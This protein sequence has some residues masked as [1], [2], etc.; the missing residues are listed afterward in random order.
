MGR[1]APAAAPVAANEA[2][3]ANTAGRKVLYWYDP[4][5]P[6]QHFDKPGKSPFMDMQL[7]PKYADEGGGAGGVRIDPD[8]AQN[9]GIRLASVQRGTFDAPIDVVANV[10]FNDRDVAVVQAR[11]GGFVQRVYARAPGDVIARGAPL[12][13]LLVP[14]WGGAQGEFL[15][16]LRTGDKSLIDAARERLTLLGMPPGLIARVERTGTSH[17]TFT[18]TA[19]IGG[20]IQS[21][22]VREGMTIAAGMTLAKINGLST[23]WLE[24]AVPESQGGLVSVGHPAEAHLAAYPGE[25]FKGKVI[26]V[27]P[28]TDT[29]SRTLKVRVELPN[30]DG[31]LK[32]GM[33]AQVRL[34]TGKTQ[35]VLMIP[36]EAVIRT[37]VRNVVIVAQNGGRYAPVEVRLGQEAA[38][39]TAILAGLSEGQK[40]VA[41]GQFLIDSE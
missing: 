25:T 21:L 22:D 19:P 28:Q 17:D 2:P 36:T 18:I 33:F 24:A 31:R 1:S 5:M 16:V 3:A 9:L 23:V 40:V 20:V 12:A 8:M 27:L 6:N 13:D 35:P 4:M 14:E 7:V 37:G 26:A 38:G 29:A 11:S 15:A 41:S 32:P 34:Q 39:K 10:L 30:R